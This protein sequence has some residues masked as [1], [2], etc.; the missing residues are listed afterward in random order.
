MWTHFTLILQHLHFT[1]RTAS[2]KGQLTA[3]LAFHPRP[4][5]IVRAIQY[6][7]PLHDITG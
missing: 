4:A 6:T 7:L 5:F 2:S 3:G 1:A